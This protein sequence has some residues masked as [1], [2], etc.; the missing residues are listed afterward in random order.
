MALDE[1]GLTPKQ[2][3]FCDYYLQC[4]NASEAARKAGYKFPEQSA[5][6]NT[7][8]PTCKA[9]LAQRMQPTVDKRIADADEVLQYLSDVMR[10]AI[11]DQFG[12]DASLQDRTKAAQELMKRYAVA[13]MR[14]ASTMQRLDSLF[15]EFRA[16]LAS[17]AT[18][19]TAPPESAPQPEAQPEAHSPEDGPQPEAMPSAGTDTTTPEGGAP[20]A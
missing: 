14:Q 18:A 10:G 6:D 4:G 3:A 7:R 17:D 8:K 16:A 1:Y 9:Y 20:T 15:V 11:K 13:D 2:R 5:K 19:P 12:L